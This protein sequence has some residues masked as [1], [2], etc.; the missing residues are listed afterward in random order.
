MVCTFS[1]TVDIKK[2]QVTVW[3]YASE[4]KVGSYREMRGRGKT[5][6][7]RKRPG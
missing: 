2:F 1:N 4:W 7:K 5:V 6:D 3:L